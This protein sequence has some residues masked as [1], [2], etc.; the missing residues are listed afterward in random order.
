ML[1]VRTSAQDAGK[2]RLTQKSTKVR[3]TAMAAQPAP[4]MGS[5]ALP[6]DGNQWEDGSKGSETSAYAT[7]SGSSVKSLSSPSGRIRT[8]KAGKLCR[9]KET[10]TQDITGTGG[11]Q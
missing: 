4:E 1:L 3:T 6:M 8:G 5:L 2:G 7:Q 9:R 10:A 11:Y